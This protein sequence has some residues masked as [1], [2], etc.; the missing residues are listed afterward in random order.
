MLF[1][2]NENLVRAAIVSGEVGAL[3]P[4]PPVLLPELELAGGDLGVEAEVV[5]AVGVCVSESREVLTV[6]L[7]LPLHAPA[8]LGCFER[9]GEEA[10]PDRAIKNSTYSVEE[11]LLAGKANRGAGEPGAEPGAQ[12]KFC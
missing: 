11:Q 6:C 3:D 2:L 10:G 8:I 7:Y 9:P 4:L 1:V 12:L 5:G